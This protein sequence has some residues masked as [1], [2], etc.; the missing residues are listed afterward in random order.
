MADNDDP[1]I[2]TL[3]RFWNVESLGVLDE[4]ID[5]PVQPF[6]QTVLFNNNQY[7][8]GLPWKEGHPDIPSHFNVCLNRLRLLHRRLLNTPELLKEYDCIIQEQLDKRILEPVPSDHLLSSI[9]YL[10]HHGV[11][12]Q[13][14]LTTKLRVVYDGS[15]KLQNDTVSLNDCLETGP[16]LIPKLFDVL[17]KFRWHRITLTADIEK[18][19]LMVGIVPCDRDMLR[20]LWLEDPS[21]IESRI[22]ELRFTRLV[23]GLRPSPAILG[24]VIAHHLD[25]YPSTVVQAIKDSFYVDDLIAGGETMKEAFNIYQVARKTPGRRGCIGITSDV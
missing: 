19:F 7:E 8:V 3:Q 23:F 17:I 5:Q 18:A 12:R 10:P 13:D 1:L 4:K 21:N 15:A 9:H 14:K 16:N 24:T 22:L 20:F 11:I 25:K 6:L 2:S